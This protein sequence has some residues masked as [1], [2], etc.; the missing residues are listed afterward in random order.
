MGRKVGQAVA[1]EIVDAVEAVPFHEG[2]H[3]FA[4]WT[5][6]PVAVLHHAG[7]D[8]DCVATQKKELRRVVSGLDPAD[9]TEGAAGEIRRES[10]RRFPCTFAERWGGWPCRN[11]RRACCSPRR[12]APVAGNLQ[13]DTHHARIVLIALTP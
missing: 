5:N 10:L 1:A 11:S 4:K 2:E 9:A 8:L 13:I 12:W 3:S 6:A 7:T